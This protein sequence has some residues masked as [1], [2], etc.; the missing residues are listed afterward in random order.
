MRLDI[1]ASLHPSGAWSRWMLAPLLALMLLLTA[2]GGSGDSSK[3]DQARATVLVYVVGSN[4][5]GGDNQATGNL[6]EMMKVGSSQDVNIIVETGGAD[7]EGWRTVKRQKVL[8]GSLEVLADVGAQKMTDPA[9]LQK[10]IEWGVDNYPAK[11]Y[12][13][14]LWNH[15]GGPLGG[16][17][18]DS[19]FPP[20][21]PMSM[22]ELVSALDG[23][24]QTTGATFD[25]IGFDA[26]LMAS[27]EIAHMLS[28][29]ANYLVASQEVEPGPGWDW[30][31][32]LD[33]L[34]N[35]SGSTAVSSGKAIIDG[36][37][38]KTATSEEHFATLS[39]TDLSKSAA[40]MESMDNAAHT[41]VDK[42]SSGSA[43]QQFNAWADLAY[44]RRATHDFQT[45]W[46]FGGMYDLADVND[47]FGQ[48]SLRMLDVSEE[49]ADA[50]QS[51]LNEAVVYN[52][53]GKDIWAPGGLTFYMPLVTAK[54]EYGDY[55][56]KKHAALNVPDGLKNLVRRYVELAATPNLPRP[57]LA[58]ITQT[59]D[60]TYA[61]LDN[62]NFAALEYANLW[63]TSDPAGRR[64]LAIKP[65]DADAPPRDGEVR[66]AAHPGE[67]WFRLPSVQGEPVL[68]SVLP[69]DSPRMAA[70]YAIYTVPIFAVADDEDGDG[71]IN[72]LPGVLLVEYNEDYQTSAKTYRVVGFL[73]HN[74]ASPLASRADPT[75]L[76]QGQKF[77]PLV[78]INKEWVPDISR[79]II[80]FDAGDENTPQDQWWQLKPATAQEL[81]G[82]NCDFSFGIVDYQGTMTM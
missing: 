56:V 52:K 78:L 53:H 46:L 60:M 50:V 25:L 43:T 40:L 3:D 24:K 12:H 2:C 22:P 75:I 38:A 6:E 35:D 55:F 8:K 59:G 34:V 44:A 20:E 29:Y 16:F 33:H 4:L 37:S 14:V 65:L 73:E 5:E 32:Y 21:I 48:I 49:Q 58:N 74:G 54:A 81:C 15:G 30:T 9:N 10:F 77:H 11:F 64:H 18:G 79:T 69:D 67:G 41:I 66:I 82:A 26:C 57:S 17:G 1:S 47:F 80:G 72:G 27:A 36:Y 68:V 23:A 39:L 61:R 42:L 51:A 19:N 76:K 62:A 7:K 71:D 31:V 45:S 13:L 63:D 28:S 70:G